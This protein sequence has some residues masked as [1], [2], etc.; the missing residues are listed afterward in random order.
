[1]PVT[2][3]MRFDSAKKAAIPAM[4]QMSSSSKPW[5]FST[6]KSASP[7]VSAE[8]ETLRRE[9]E[10]SFLPRRDIGLSVVDCHL[11]GDQRVLRPDTQDRAVRDYAVLTLV[12]IRGG[13]H[14]HLAF[15]L[16]QVT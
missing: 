15:G 12:C 7:T 4:S 10:H 3:A 5:G 16:R 8:R 11:V 14:D 2:F 6:S 13:Y 9:V 1:M